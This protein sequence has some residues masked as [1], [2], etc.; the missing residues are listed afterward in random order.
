MTLTLIT[1]AP[2]HQL[3]PSPAASWRRMVAAGCPDAITEA[4]RSTETQAARRAAY[5]A[6]TGAFALP[7]GESRHET[8]EALD[9][10]RAATT[11]V[12]DHPEYGWRF[13]NDD[14]WWH[15]EHF[16]HL[17]QHRTDPPQEE[18]DMDT[19]QAQALAETHAAAGR[20]ELLL[21]EAIPKLRQEVSDIRNG[22]AGMPALIAAVAGGDVDEAAI[23]AEVARV[24]PEYE[25]TIA[26]K[27]DCP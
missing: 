17:D 21:T 18:P 23:A 13:T 9:L 27:G 7:P 3:A 14:E 4:W 16:D 8:G 22:V 19:A 6:G 20:L 12:R 2:G 15:A 10:K 25:V 24:L 1:I 11:W 5:L 26:R